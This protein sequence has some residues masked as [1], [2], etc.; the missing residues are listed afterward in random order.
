VKTNN[1]GGNAVSIESQGGAGGGTETNLQN[2]CCGPGGGGG[3]GVIWVSTLSTT[4]GLNFAVNSGSNG[5]TSSTASCPNSANGA[6]AGGGGGLLITFDLAAPRDSSPVCTQ[7]VPLYLNASI[8]GYQQGGSRYFTASVSNKYN[9]Q[10]CSL[11]K[12]FTAGDFTTMA[13]QNSNNSEQYLFTDAAADRT[14]IY[15]IKVVTK[16]G[17][18]VYSPVLRM[19]AGNADKKLSVDVY[20]N[21]SRQKISVQVYAEAAGTGTMSF[22]DARGRLLKT[23]NQFFVKGYNVFSVSLQEL[24]AGVV[25]LKINSAGSTVVRPLLK[26]AE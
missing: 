9:V 23:Q 10:Q 15:R 25:F 17:F 11:Q 4:G 20:P 7:L 16:D 18:V 24:P 8:T 21:P 1:F 14:A 2:Q 13:S 12:A 26:M 6:T 22:T 3:G 5:T 19:S